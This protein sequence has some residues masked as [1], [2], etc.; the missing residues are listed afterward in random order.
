MK[1]FELR[2]EKKEKLEKLSKN[3]WRPWYDK[4]FGVIVRASS[5]KRAREIAADN[6]G[7][8]GKDAWLD[9]KYSTCV[10]L[11]HKGEEGLIM[12][13]VSDA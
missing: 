6:C 12:E 5:K 7:D 8:E 13:D 11:T 2:P 1:L 10:K 9:P 4:C 3:P